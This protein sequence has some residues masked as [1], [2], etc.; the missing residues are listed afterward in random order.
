MGW[1]QLANNL[2]LCQTPIIY[3]FSPLPLHF[4]HGDREA[5]PSG[6]LP[7]QQLLLIHWLQSL[8]LGLRWAAEKRGAPP[9]HSSALGRTENHR[10]LELRFNLRL[11]HF[12]RKNLMQL[13]SFQTLAWTINRSQGE[14]RAGARQRKCHRA[15]LATDNCKP[16]GYWCPLQ[17]FPLSPSVNSFSAPPPRKSG[18]L[19]P[20]WTPLEFNEVIWLLPK[21]SWLDFE[22]WEGD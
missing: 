6:I 4:Y 5:D 20:P 3:V 7:L 17:Y 13:T 14:P 18:E 1:T 8:G 11:P 21:D 22:C 16:F 12:L 9:T 10:S 15:L 19:C 2:R